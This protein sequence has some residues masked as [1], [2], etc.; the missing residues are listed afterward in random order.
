MCLLV[1]CAK[2]RHLNCFIKSAPKNKSIFLLQNENAFKIKY[3]L[4]LDSL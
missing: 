1:A 2:N 4:V 3:N